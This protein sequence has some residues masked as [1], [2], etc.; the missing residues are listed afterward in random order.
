MFLMGTV[1]LTSKTFRRYTKYRWPHL[2]CVYMNI[3]TGY[4]PYLT[5][6]AVWNMNYV[7]RTLIDEP[8]QYY[9]PTSYWILCLVPPRMLYCP[10]KR[11]KANHDGD[12]MV[13]SE[14]ICKPAVLCCRILLCHMLSMLSGLRWY[15]YRYSNSLRLNDAIW[16]HR[17]WSTFALLMACCLTAPS[18]YLNQCWLSSVRSS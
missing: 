14:N 17:S 12:F 2:S 16:R 8:Q 9:N 4:G 6:C 13:C 15:I 1:V 18:Y 7:C 10:V 11:N 3:I 5:R